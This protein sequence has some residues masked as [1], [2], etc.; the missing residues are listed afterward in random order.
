MTWYYLSLRIHGMISLKKKEVMVKGWQLKI[1]KVIFLPSFVENPML[2]NG[3]AAACSLCS[4]LSL[5]KDPGATLCGL[6]SL[7][8]FG[9]SGSVK[10]RGLANLRLGIWNRTIGLEDRRLPHSVGYRLLSSVTVLTSSAWTY[11][12]CLILIL[13]LRKWNIPIILKK[14]INIYLVLCVILLVRPFRHN[15]QDLMHYILT[16]IWN[17]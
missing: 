2:D 6:F 13:E 17:A 7:V 11:R 8:E 12:R 5:F 3:R 1:N 16:F 4:P 10:V 15:M 14:I 9:G